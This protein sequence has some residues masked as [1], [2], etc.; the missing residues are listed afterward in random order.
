MKKAI[1]V[2]ILILFIKISAH[3]AARPFAEVGTSWTYVWSFEGGFTV[4]YSCIKDTII[5]GKSCSLIN[6]S[7]RTNGPGPNIHSFPDSIYIYED[8]GRVFLYDSTSK[9]FAKIVDFNL[10][11]GDTL[12]VKWHRDTFALEIDS[13]GK[14]II[15]G[16][17]L[18]LLMFNGYN[19]D[20]FID[21]I[22]GAYWLLPRSFKT[23]YGFQGLRCFQDSTIGHYSPN[24]VRDCDTS[25]AGISKINEPRAYLSI[26]PEPAH[27]FINL[28]FTGIEGKVNLTVNDALG[29]LVLRRTIEAN[30]ENRLDI[31]ALR[32]GLYLAVMSNGN[33]SSSVKFI[34]N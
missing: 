34:K 20:P 18:D 11:K 24:N 2:I 3:S 16:K 28:N 7:F 8:S 32:A 9:G 31:S 4:G 26:F 29:R 5:R 30:E 13:I 10:K 25:W 21:S 1:L 17:S 27:D 14:E 6:I 33:L 15:N 12:H 23:F 22:G 19:D